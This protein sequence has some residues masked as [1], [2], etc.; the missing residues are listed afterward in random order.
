[1]ISNAVYKEENKINPVELQLSTCRSQKKNSISCEM[2]PSPH[3]VHQKHKGSA[4]PQLKLWIAQTKDPFLPQYIFNL[5]RSCMRQPTEQKKKFHP[6]KVSRMYFNNEQPGGNR[7]DDAHDHQCSIKK[8]KTLL[9]QV[10][11]L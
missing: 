6:V 5:C 10:V 3:H 7:S 4:Q 2:C 8:M 9:T 11:N 1:M